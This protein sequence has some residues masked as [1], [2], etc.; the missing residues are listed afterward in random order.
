MYLVDLCLDRSGREPLSFEVYIAT[1]YF[2]I[3]PH[4]G[5]DLGPRPISAILLQWLPR[6]EPLLFTINWV[7]CFL[8]RLAYV[9]F[10][11]SVLSVS[12]G[13]LY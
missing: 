10:Q 6:G 3:L 8:F 9:C 5:Y 4:V 11:I 7:W 12:L 1:I 13:F 2:R